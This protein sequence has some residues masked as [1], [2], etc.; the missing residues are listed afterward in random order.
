LD[1]RFAD[2]PQIEAAAGRF[3]LQQMVA[4]AELEA[5]M[6]LAH[7]KVALAAKKRANTVGGRPRKIVSLDERSKRI[8]SNRHGK[9]AIGNNQRQ[10]ERDATG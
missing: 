3:T 4:V 1:F 10:Y 9:T 8:Y 2:P 7:T 5:G 6:I